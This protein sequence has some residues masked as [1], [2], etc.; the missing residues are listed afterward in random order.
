MANETTVTYDFAQIDSND[1]NDQNSYLELT[2]TEDVNYWN[3]NNFEK[4]VKFIESRS[5]M[6]TLL[7][8]TDRNKLELFDT[9]LLEYKYLLL[10]LF[11]YLPKWYNIHNFVERIKLKLNSKDINLMYKTLKE[12]ELIL[13]GV[14]FAKKEVFNIKKFT[15]GIHLQIMK[16]K[17]Q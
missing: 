17:N 10:K 7:T 3:V 2:I 16:M 4:M 12:K 8:K 1:E 14:I 15:I 11:F 5:K 6:R 13:T 9:L